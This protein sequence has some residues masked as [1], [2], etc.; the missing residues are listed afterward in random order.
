GRW[1]GWGGGGGGRA[2]DQGR[3]GVPAPQGD[4]GPGADDG[5]VRADR[6]EA[7]QA[8]RAAADRVGFPRV[9]AVLRERAPRLVRGGRRQARYGGVPGEEALSAR[10]LSGGATTPSS[11]L[12][13]SRR[14]A[15]GR[16]APRSPRPRTARAGAPRRP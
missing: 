12:R 7:E 2:E 3:A 14:R 4:D 16:R 5:A 13:P 6:D 15:P 8:V 1:G 10:R 9:R 11:A